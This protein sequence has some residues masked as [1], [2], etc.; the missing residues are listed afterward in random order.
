MS[1]FGWNWWNGKGEI[2]ETRREAIRPREEERAIQETRLKSR[3]RQH[4][5]SREGGDRD[6]WFLHALLPGGPASA[7][8]ARNPA[9]PGDYY[10]RS[11]RRRVQ[12]SRPQAETSGRG[13]WGCQAEKSDWG[14]QGPQWC[15]SPNLAPVFPKAPRPP[16]PPATPAV[17]TTPLS[18]WSLLYLLGGQS[19]TTHRAGT[20]MGL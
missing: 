13:R 19:D 7:R 12:G 14:A 17:K 20:G 16:P 2:A 3:Q 9:A 11:G 10:F 15:W 8:S 18:G 6:L 1:V 4:T 5:L